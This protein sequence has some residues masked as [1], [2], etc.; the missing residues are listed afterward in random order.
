MRSLI[1]KFVELPDKKLR[2]GLSYSLARD[3]GRALKPPAR[4]WRPS[5]LV[6]KRAPLAGGHD[7]GDFDNPWLATIWHKGTFICGATIIG[8][9]ML[10][11]AAHCVQYFK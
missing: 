10:V 2:L 11:T 3:C 9:N 6:I 4:K 7:A 5:H 1:S 8:R